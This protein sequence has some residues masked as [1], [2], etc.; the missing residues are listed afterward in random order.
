MIYIPDKIKVGYQNR[1][2][3]Y[4]GKLAYVIYYDRY[5]K[6]RK[7]PSWNI[8]RDEKIKPNEFDN[9]PTE[10]F[11]LNKKVGGYCYHFD[12]R[13]TY[14]RVYDPRGFEFEIS[15]PNLLYI[16]EYANSIR[17][18]GLE[19]EFVYGWDG[20]ELVLVP[21]SSED[22]K[23]KDKTEDELY[24]LE[25]IAPS[26]LR[27][28]FMY[29]SK[30]GEIVYMGKFDYYDYNGEKTGK[31]Y[32]YFAHWIWSREHADE[33]WYLQ[34]RSQLK[35]IVTD[36]IGDTPFEGYSELVDKMESSQEYS[37]IDKSK[38]KYRLATPEE[39]HHLLERWCSACYSQEY[40]C[41]VIIQ[42]PDKES[43]VAYVYDT[44]SQFNKTKDML[45]RA[46]NE[47]GIYNTLK[48]MKLEFY[49]A[50]GRLFDARWEIMK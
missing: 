10:G 9:S 48:P 40:E 16:L 4:T 25:C 23:N 44:R 24:P 8:W 6:L 46:K 38:C 7:E 14:V 45:I 22:Y 29:K 28:G 41:S 30:Y 33:N 32:F 31:K 35:Q 27:P 12:Q 43:Y 37:P 49:L 13:D 3:T 36:Q 19:G 1:K 50:N 47:A 15:V 17:G 2:D 21:T 39:F 26:K 18:K 20:T 42:K 34:T 11:V 5:G